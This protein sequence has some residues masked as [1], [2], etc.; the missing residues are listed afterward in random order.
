MLES[1]EVS[2]PIVLGFKINK[3]ENGITVD[4]TYYKQ[5]VGSLMYLT[6]TR[7]DMMFVTSLI[8]RFIAK[9]TELHLKVAKRAI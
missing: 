5:L 9:P 2:S 4:E 7:P 1:N 8:S 3:D 6:A